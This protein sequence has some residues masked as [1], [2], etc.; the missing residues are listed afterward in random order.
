[1]QITFGEKEIK[2]LSHRL[3]LNERDMIHAYR[4]YIQEKRCSHKLL[5]LLH[6]LPISSRESERGFSQMNLIITPIRASLLTITV[7][8]LLFIQLAGPPLIC[9]DPSKY[10]DSWLFQGRHSA[11][12][13][14]SLKR[15]RED[16]SDEDS[17]KLWNYM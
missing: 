11:I 7:S 17:I 3:Q 5:L 15:K 6:T 8:K 10:V 13:T 1:M 9:F 14:K 16:T 12:D 4:E 2:K